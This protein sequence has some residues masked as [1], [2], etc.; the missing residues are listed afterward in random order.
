MAYTFSKSGTLRW[1]QVATHQDE[2][3]AIVSHQY[4]DR[5]NW[6]GMIDPNGGVHSQNY[7]A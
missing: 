7:D 2:I 3:S 5:A 4:D 6:I 1:H